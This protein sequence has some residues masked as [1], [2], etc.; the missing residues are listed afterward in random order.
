MNGTIHSLDSYEMT[1][2]LTYYPLRYTA[3]LS[4]VY[5]IVLK[6]ALLFPSLRASLIAT[7]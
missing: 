2:N 1:R 7:G 5:G 4:C 3:M 6:V